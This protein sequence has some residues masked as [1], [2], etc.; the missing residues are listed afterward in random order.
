MRSKRDLFPGVVLACLLAI[1]SAHAE[2]GVLDRYQKRVAATLVDQPHWATPF[3]TVAPRVE[4]GIRAD[5]VRQTTPGGQQIWNLGNTK[6]LQLVPFRRVELRFSP[7]PF[8]V[9]S[10]PQLSDGFGDMAFR[11]KYRLYG[12]NEEHHNAIVTGILGASVPTGKSGNGSCC[13]I[14]TPT[15][16]LGKGYGKFA[17]TSTIGGALPVSN[18]AKLGRQIVW[19]SALQF[20][21]S[22]FVW[23]ETEFNSTFFKGGKNDGKSQTFVTPGIIVSRIPLTHDAAG[24]PGRLLLTLGVA[25]QIALTHFNTYNHS[26]IVTARLRF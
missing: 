7:A 8:L 20:H 2:D 18:A 22:R 14:L 15:L 10:D 21:A 23:L 12:S 19:N 11:V 26:P 6:G 17:F 4:Q 1:G 3:I 13:A 25:E 16:A 9:H 24:K 5:F